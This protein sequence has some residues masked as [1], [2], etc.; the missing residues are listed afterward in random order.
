MLRGNPWTQTLLL[1]LLI[2]IENIVLFTKEEEKCVCTRKKIKTWLAIYKKVLTIYNVHKY[3][4][5][6]LLLLQPCLHLLEMLIVLDDRLPART[7][8]YLRE[9]V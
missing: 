5:F 6:L 4:Q 1:L 9:V 7:R 2:K 8:V 3:L